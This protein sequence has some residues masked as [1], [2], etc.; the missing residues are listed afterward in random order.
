MQAVSAPRPSRRLLGSVAKQ[1]L[2]LCCILAV[3][4]PDMD[5]VFARISPPRRLSLRNIMAACARTSTSTSACA[6]RSLLFSPSAFAIRLPAS[7]LCVWQDHDIA[8]LLLCSFG[9]PVGW[10]QATGVMR[11]AA[12]YVA[13]FSLAA[14]DE[15]YPARACA[16]HLSEAA[17]GFSLY[18]CHKVS[19]P[20]LYLY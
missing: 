14:S 1:R 19:Q 10:Q 12:V 11:P 15:A 13:A 8:V 18:A 6:R 17:G 7:Q 5:S 2:G 9:V 16:R 4:R 20:L 3:H